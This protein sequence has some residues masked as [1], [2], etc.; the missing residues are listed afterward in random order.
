MLSIV[1]LTMTGFKI[2]QYPQNNEYPIAINQAYEFFMEAKKLADLD[3]SKLWG[4]YMYGPMMFVDPKTR[5]IVANEADLEGKLSKECDVFIGYLDKRQGIANTSIQWAGKQWM[6][7]NWDFLPKN[8]P[9]KRKNLMMHEHFHRIQG[10]IPLSAG[11]ANN[12]HLDKM[13]G[14]IWLKME[15]NALEKAI[16]SKGNERSQA[17][18]DALTFRN[19]RHELFPNAKQNEQQLEINEGMAEYTGFILSHLKKQDQL[20]YFKTNI[21]AYKMSTSYVR[22][23]AYL[24]GPI[25]G[26]LLYEKNKKWNKNL[27]AES[28][29]GDFL[30]SA[31]NIVLP[32]NLGKTVKERTGFYNYDYVYQIE[33]D[34]EIARIELNKQ[35]CEKFIKGPVIR[36]DLQKMN[37]TFNPSNLKS[38]NGY[39]TVYPS[40]KM[41]DVWGTL[42]V[43]GGMALMDDKWSTVK[44]SAKNLK[45]QSN[46]IAGEGWTLKFGHESELISGKRPGDFELRKI[47]SVKKELSIKNLKQK[48][49]KN[50][51]LICKTDSLL[52]YKFSPGADIKMPDVG[53]VYKAP[54][55]I[56]DVWGL[57]KVEKGYTFINK[58]RT[59]FLVGLP[60]KEEN[61]KISGDGWVLYPNDGWMLKQKE[62]NMILIRK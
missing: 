55:S 24:S 49:L 9:L 62:R 43:D 1:V 33:H 15:W 3:D 56:T 11:S 17:I 23:F 37:F 20:D 36:F 13:W 34:L 7:I 26:Y 50:P 28:D 19:Y 22:S 61:G 4:V 60:L 32:D 27:N 48:F 44:V 53:I 41:T 52:R 6:M 21:T 10:E 2:T 25:Y 38:F 57:L 47:E 58:E 29:L 12:P 31:Y 51:V 18:K 45:I 30:Q 42:E 39:G 16:F 35:F 14:R 46:L 5:F 8:F 54:I 59:H 40:M